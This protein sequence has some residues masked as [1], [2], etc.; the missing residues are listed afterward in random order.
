VCQLAD[1]LEGVDVRALLR[2]EVQVVTDQA[3]TPAYSPAADTWLRK[4]V[5]ISAETI[6]A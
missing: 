2:L 1:G 5:A 6:C 4:I 3:E